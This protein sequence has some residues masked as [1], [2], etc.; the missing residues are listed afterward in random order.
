MDP[1]VREVMPPSCIRDPRAE[2][3]W[4]V[5]VTYRALCLGSELDVGA[6]VARLNVPMWNSG[7]VTLASVPSL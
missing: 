6:K 7:K 1:G 4:D 3:T 2:Q 5:A